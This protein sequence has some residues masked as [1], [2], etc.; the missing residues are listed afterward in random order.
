[1]VSVDSPLIVY[2]VKLTVLFFVL[3]LSPF[4][5]W[6]ATSKPSPIEPKSVTQ[7]GADAVATSLDY[8]Q[9]SGVTTLGKNVLISIHD[10]KSKKSH[11]IPVGG[12]KAGISI[13]NYNAKT[14]S[15]VVKCGKKSALLT[16]RIAA[17]QGKSSITQKN[18]VTTLDE[19]YGRPL[20]V[21]EQET[22]ARMLVSDLLEI[23]ME[24]RARQQKLREKR[25]KK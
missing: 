6:S 20:T 12:T 1:M 11:W 23:G 5:G 14:N 17:N 3:V 9:I 21:K 10:S 25:N 8:L 13:L 4:I 19:E 2:K 7:N 18:K 24:E 16:L 15:V 22:E